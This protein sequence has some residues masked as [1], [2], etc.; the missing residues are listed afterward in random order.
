[1]TNTITRYNDPMYYDNTFA[2]MGINR[3]VLPEN[4]HSAGLGGHGCVF[5]RPPCG[6]KR[7]HIITDFPLLLS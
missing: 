7:P 4:V 6:A 2:D 3:D 1:M 5:Q